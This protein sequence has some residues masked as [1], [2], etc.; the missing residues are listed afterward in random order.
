[1]IDKLF[2]IMLDRLRCPDCLSE[3][4][5]DSVPSDVWTDAETW[6]TMWFCGPCHA[7]YERE[8]V[9]SYADVPEG[10]LLVTD[11]VRA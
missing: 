11:G 6:K 4:S 9:S 10:C 5:A 7:Y 8:D 3:I 2:D 1:M